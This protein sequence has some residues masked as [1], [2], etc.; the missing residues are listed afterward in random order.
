[1]SCAA[2]I[3]HDVELTLREAGDADFLTEQPWLQL[4]APL[5]AGDVLHVRAETTL[6]VP[7]DGEPR[8]T[9]TGTVTRG[10]ETIATIAGG[11]TDTAGRA[12]SPAAATAATSDPVSPAANPV[13]AVLDLLATPAPERHARPALTLAVGDDVAPASMDAFARV[14]GDRN[15]LHRS[16]LAARLAG[17][18]RPIVHGAWTA[19]RASA[20]VVDELCDGDAA[21]L[22]EWRVS[23]LAPVSLGAAL[24]F[25]ATRSAIVDGRRVVQVRVRANDVDVALGEAVIDGP[26]T[27]LI[28]PGQGI[29]RAGLGAEGRAR[30]RA[31]RAV[32]ASR[33]R[34]HPRSARLLAARSRRGQPARA[35]ARGRARRPASRRRPVPHRVHPGGAGRARRRAGRGATGGGRSRRPARGRRAQR[36]GVRGAAR[37]RRALARG[38]ADPRLAARTRDAAPR[39]ARG[40]RFLAVPARG[41]DSRSTGSPTTSRSSTTTRRTASTRSSAR[42]TRSPRSAAKREWCRASTSRSTRPRCAAPWTSSARTS[43]RRASIRRRSYGRWVPNVLAR[44]LEPGDDVVELLAQQLASPVRWIECQQALARLVG[45]F[46]EI[47]PAH[48]AVLTGLARMTVPDVEVLHAE[49]DRDVVLERAVASAPAAVPAGADASAR[50]ESTR[51]DDS[52]ATGAAPIAAARHSPD[53]WRIVPSTRA[54]RSSSCSPCRRGCGSTSSTRRSRSTSSSRACRRGATRC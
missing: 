30:S 47:A 52:V 4:R 41:R 16:V 3:V 2:T 43:R 54:T 22:R 12:T 49:H 1:M 9:A 17:L 35:A 28:F 38:G 14:G 32:W 15:P 25:E 5:V 26:P 24:D 33:R 36:G 13:T 27:A 39:S 48:A 20:F 19:A 50:D 21:R 8:W 53:T 40:G 37:A 51:A 7:R 46:L 29:Q 6:E 11:H 31:A 34:S 42:R 45:R 18:K 44:P 23:F 10:D